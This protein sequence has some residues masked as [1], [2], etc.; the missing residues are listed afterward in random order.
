MVAAYNARPHGGLPKIMDAETGKRRHM[1]PLEAWAA[2]MAD[3]WTPD[4]PETG[5]LDALFRPQ[6]KR[7]VTR[8]QIR[9]YN[10]HYF[11]KALDA[12][13]GREV[14]VGYD[15]HDA[16][17]VWISDDKGRLICVAERD[18]NLVDYF[19]A[20]T[21]AEAQAKRREVGRLRRVDAKRQAILDERRATL[22]HA[23]N[24]EILPTINTPP[25]QEPAEEIDARWVEEAVISLERAAG[26]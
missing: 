1:A 11:S 3:G 13:H 19:P 8:C 24:V 26:D 25:E 12:Y 22:E 4:Q 23:S 18:G 21:V 16:S 6:E 9:L 10:H 2:A 20:E 5:E 17:K 14:R 15:P 7:R